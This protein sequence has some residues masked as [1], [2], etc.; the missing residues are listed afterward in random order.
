MSI[1]SIFTHSPKQPPH[2]Q[3]QTP[4]WK[5]SYL[6]YP[7][8]TK[9]LLYKKKGQKEGGGAFQSCWFRLCNA[10]ILHVKEER[11]AIAP[12]VSPP[13]CGFVWSVTEGG[14]FYHLQPPGNKTVWLT[15]IVCQITHLF[16]LTTNE[17]T[18]FL[19]HKWQSKRWHMKCLSHI[20]SLKPLMYLFAKQ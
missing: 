11:Q 4:K 13:G 12:K 1:F 15:S 7:I 16:V 3:L 20:T 2:P 6:N 19:W 10:K 5:H 14:V 17:C 8:R 18:L 9:E